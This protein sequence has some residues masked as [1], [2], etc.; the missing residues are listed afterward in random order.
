[1]YVSSKLATG[2]VLMV[3]LAVALWGLGG[4]ALQARG[5]RQSCPGTCPVDPHAQHEADEDR[6]RALAREQKE[7]DH[8]QH[9]ADEALAKEQKEAEHAQ[10]EAAE[11]CERQQK[12]YSK[13]QQEAADAQAR[14]DDK[15]AK[16]TELGGMCKAIEPVAEVQPEPEIYRAKP[17]PEPE[18]VVPE[19]APIVEQPAP[20]EKPT[21]L[22]RTASSQELIGLIGLLS[23]T[24]A[25]TGFFR[26]NR[27]R[28]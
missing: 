21:E 11:D 13:A 9:E 26:A 4:P 16:A 8:A 17:M 1:M 5:A 15:L 19:P 20:V 22:P 10:H 7:A 18:P 14:A 27:R 3:A 25:V 2:R 24:G 6:E 12:A 28:K 23:V